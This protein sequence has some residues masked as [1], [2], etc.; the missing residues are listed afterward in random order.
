MNSGRFWMREDSVPSQ[1]SADH[2]EKEAEHGGRKIEFPQ[3]CKCLYHGSPFDERILCGK[4]LPIGFALFHQ[5]N[6]T[7]ERRKSQEAAGRMT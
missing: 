6:F 5:H 7:R 4:T 1:V 3:E 2:G